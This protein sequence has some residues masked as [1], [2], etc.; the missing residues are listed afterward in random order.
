MLNSGWADAMIAT[1]AK[2]DI[3]PNIN[4]LT[5]SPNTYYSHNDEYYIGGTFI[6]H[7]MNNKGE[8]LTNKI[9]TEIGK[10]WWAPILGT[11][12]PGFVIDR[13]M[14]KV[15][16]KDSNDLYDAWKNQMRE[17]FLDWKWEGER[18]TFDGWYKKYVTV[19][20]NN[21]YYMKMV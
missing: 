5:H 13:S 20:Q 10:Y 19:W 11:T 18:I 21:I 4:E 16:G 6:H 14:K 7:L 2:Y 3:L 17:K 1:Q 15:Y 12:F 8:D 9:I